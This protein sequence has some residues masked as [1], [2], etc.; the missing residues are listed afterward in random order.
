MLPFGMIEQ[1]LKLINILLESTPPAQREA[2]LRIWFDLWWPFWKMF[3][4]PEQISEIERIMKKN[5]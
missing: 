2:Q 1:A 5:D 4:K 3:L